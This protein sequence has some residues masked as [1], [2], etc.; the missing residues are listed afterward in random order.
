MRVARSSISGRTTRHP[1]CPEVRFYSFELEPVGPMISSIPVS[2]QQCSSI[3]S[4][5]WATLA[6]RVLSSSGTLE[7]CSVRSDT[8]TSKSQQLQL[9]FSSPKPYLRRR[10]S[11]CTRSGG[12]PSGIRSR[13]LPPACPPARRKRGS[14]ARFLPQPHRFPSRYQRNDYRYAQTRR[15]PE[16]LLSYRATRSRRPRQPR[17]TRTG[18]ANHRGNGS[19]RCALNSLRPTSTSQRGFVPRRR[20]SASPCGIRR[21]NLRE[22]R[23]DTPTSVSRGRRHSSTGN[24]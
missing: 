15:H 16:G 1:C 6:A 17:S 23:F 3:A 2:G 14:R 24:S 4:E 22:P 8:C 12:N 20:R 18:R 11:R 10:S 5:R 7:C 21:F 9:P 19:H 13:C